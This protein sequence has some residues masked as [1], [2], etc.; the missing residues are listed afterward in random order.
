MAFFQFGFSY[1]QTASHHS[2]FGVGGLL[3]FV[4]E[5]SKFSFSKTF[6]PPPAFRFRISNKCVQHVD[7]AFLKITR[8]LNWG[9]VFRVTALEWLWQMSRLAVIAHD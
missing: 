8:R 7:S 5:F 4:S 9:P 6:Q 2:M 3:S 1:P